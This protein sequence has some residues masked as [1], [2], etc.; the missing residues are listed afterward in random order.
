MTGVV[1]V[2]TAAG[3]VV[4]PPL[5]AILIASLGWRSAVITL[6]ILAAVLL[7]TAA[8]A[9]KAPPNVEEQTP[10]TLQDDISFRNVR[11]TR[12]FWTLCAIQFL[13]FPTLT[14]V[15][16]HIVVHGMDLG[17]TAALAAGLLSVTGAASVAG[18]LTVGTLA[19]R[20]RGK[21]AFIICFIPLI[22]SLLAMLVIAT[23]W[24]LYAAV[25]IY[26]FAHGGF[27]TVVSPTIAEY[28]G[29]HAHGAT[30]GT[31]LF[32]GTIG[33]ALGPILAGRVFDTTGS[34]TLAFAS[35]AALAVI[36]LVMVFSL[37][38]AAKTRFH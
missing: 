28:F 31:V 35:L 9:M 21:H 38:E 26:G 6:G 16:L 24:P 12:A 18:R 10:Q 22:A 29:T 19:D 11:R 34:Y 33:G 27:F 8:L 36:G 7:L 4:V 32:F 3:Q 2:G 23:P 13:F 5:A 20:I 25:A 14:T 1:K 17:M 30:F 15:P 37:P